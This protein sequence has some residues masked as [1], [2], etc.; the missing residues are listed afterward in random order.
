MQ[1][2]KNIADDFYIQFQKYVLNALKIKKYDFKSY[3]NGASDFLNI[4][5]S[6]IL[7]F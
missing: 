6:D 3:K 1:K 5:K 2:N 7:V 4:I